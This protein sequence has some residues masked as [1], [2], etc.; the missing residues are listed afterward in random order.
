MGQYLLEPALRT[1]PLV[2]RP[3][4]LLYEIPDDWVFQFVKVL[5]R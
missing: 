5:I 4:K 3:E 1:K 2:C